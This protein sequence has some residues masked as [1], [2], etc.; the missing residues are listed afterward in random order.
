MVVLIVVA[1]FVISMFMDEIRLLLLTLQMTFPLITK[2]GFDPT[3]WVVL[4]AGHGKLQ[5]SRW[6]VSK[7]PPELGLYC[8]F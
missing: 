2:L 7:R 8:A 3:C 4:G 5:I 1:Y 6:I